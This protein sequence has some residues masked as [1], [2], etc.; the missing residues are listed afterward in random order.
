MM[1]SLFS[2][3]TDVVEM[4]KTRQKSY[5]VI[6]GDEIVAY[7]CIVDGKLEGSTETTTSAI[8][9]IRQ[10]DLKFISYMNQGKEILSKISSDIEIYNTYYFQENFVTLQS[11]V[12]YVTD[13]GNYLYVS[14]KYLLTV[15]EFAEMMKKELER[16]AENGDNKEM[17]GAPLRLNAL[18]DLKRFDVNSPTFGA[19]PIENNGSENAGDGDINP[20]GFFDNKLVLWGSVSAACVLIIVAAV[21]V[22]KRIGKAKR[23]EE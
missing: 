2:K 18:E 9:L 1:L 6:E 7:K 14:G 17:I 23:T 4:V 10:E 22:T 20:P 15:D 12:C 21:L 8:G 5:I 11:A 16:L 13:R 19:A 3:T